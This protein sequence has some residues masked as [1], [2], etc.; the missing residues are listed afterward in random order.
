MRNPLRNLE[1]K[2]LSLV[3]AGLTWF[4]ITGQI[5]SQKGFSLA[6]KVK[7]APAMD[8]ID[9]DT[10][11]VRVTLRGP[12]AAIEQFDSTRTV[13][14]VD[15]STEKESKKIKM[16]VD[17]SKLRQIIAPLQLSIVEHSP[18]KVTIELDSRESKY[19]QVDVVVTGE[20][21]EGYRFI[22]AYAKPTNV[23]YMAA[24]S[25]LKDVN[26]I[27]TETIEISNEKETFE[28][29]VRL[30]DPLT[31]KPMPHQVTA[32][33]R[34]EPDY[35]EKLFENVPVR[36]MLDPALKKNAVVNPKILSVTLEGRSDQTDQLA[37]DD[38]VL[39][40]R[41]TAEM[42]GQYTLS[43]SIFI[44]DRYDNIRLKGQLPSVEVEVSPNL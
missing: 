20:A 37:A 42:E 18:R 7:T 38:I 14:E 17:L 21:Q 28:S 6:L 25:K 10:R 27:K 43:P 16:E 9:L 12:T 32:V 41:I 36:I 15:L 35:R 23:P 4:L 19:L 29:K 31:D 3:M 44:P 11:S 26:K 13:I 40:V 8:V 34:I 24:A 2:V 39:Y 30:L 5:I 22:N 33:I 1:L